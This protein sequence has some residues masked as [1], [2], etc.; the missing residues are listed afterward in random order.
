MVWFS[1][2]FKNF[3]QFVVKSSPVDN[4]LSE[5]CTMACPSWVALHGMAHNSIESD[6]TVIYMISLVSFLCL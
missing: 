2:P 1:H 6:K 4:I 5:L 3:L